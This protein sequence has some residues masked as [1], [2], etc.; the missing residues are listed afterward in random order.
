MSYWYRTFQILV[1]SDG[2]DSYIVRKIRWKCIPFCLCNSLVTADIHLVSQLRTTLFQSLYRNPYLVHLIR[3]RFQRSSEQNHC[4]RNPQT[5]EQIQ[6][7]QPRD[8]TQSGIQLLQLKKPMS[9]MMTLEQPRKPWF[10]FSNLSQSCGFTFK[11][12]LFLPTFAVFSY[13][14]PWDLINIFLLPLFL[15]CCRVMERCT[16]S[17]LFQSSSVYQLY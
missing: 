2:V 12:V 9:M 16:Q 10:V 8:S 4:M 14:K 15:I 7:R 1:L 6:K 5:P 3:L 11:S 17:H 13:S